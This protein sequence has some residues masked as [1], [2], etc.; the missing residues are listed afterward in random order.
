MA[1]LRRRT[2]SGSDIPFPAGLSL[3]SRA[4]GN[5]VV[6][7]GPA[8]VA[9]VVPNRMLSRDTR[10][11]P[12]QKILMRVAGGQHSPRASAR[13]AALP[14]LGLSINPRRSALVRGPLE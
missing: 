3:A 9:L 10:T 14:P 2:G 11:V 6:S 8:G 12:L 5:R 7:K 1:K 13:A 4:K